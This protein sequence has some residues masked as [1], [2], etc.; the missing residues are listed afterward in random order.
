MM[1]EQ[2][3]MKERRIVLSSHPEFVR[4]RD[5]AIEFGKA[6]MERPIPTWEEQLCCMP[7]VGIVWQWDSCLM[8]LYA[9]YTPG[10]LHAL[11]NL[12]NLYALQREDGYIGMAYEIATRKYLW[13]ER[14]NPPLYSFAEWSYAE[15]TGDT[16]RLEAAFEPIVRLYNWTKENRR[17]NNGLYWFE[18]TGSSG[19][20]NSPRSGYTAYELKGSD[21]CF[22]DLSCQQVLNAAC[23]A[24]MATFLNKDQATIDYFLE[25]AASLTELINKYHWSERTGFYHDIFCSGNKLANKTAA[26]FWTMISGV[27]GEEQVNSLVNHLKNPDTFG[28]PHPVPTLS[29]DDPNYRTDG[30]YWLGS[31][32]PAINYMVVSGL[33]KQGRRELAREIAYKHLTYMSKILEEGEHQSIWECY[34]PEKPLPATTCDPNFLCRREFVGFSGLG[35]FAM[36]PED[37]LGLDI[38]AL[39]KKIVWHISENG[40]IGMTDI[41]FNGRSVDL[42]IEC[43]QDYSFKAN[44]RTDV[45]F[46]LELSLPGRQ[47]VK[48]NITSS[49]EIVG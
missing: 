10:N 3:E 32:W 44:V 36:L 21:V 7:G 15:R 19:M 31:V 11:G 28:T 49:C 18:D 9:G 1:S 35:P 26:A 45:P 39:E 27:A 38:K 6:N 23:I 14:I 8:A 29:R 37:I 24:K 2:I 16:S 46:S 42:K 22:V 48:Y 30:G 41:P 40:E 25:E 47:P 17:R 34:S 20:D 4:L 43:G 12:T 5:K 33:R 13:G